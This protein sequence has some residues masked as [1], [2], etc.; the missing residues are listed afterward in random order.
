[1]GLSVPLDVISC[2][3]IEGPQP[4]IVEGKASLGEER[5]GGK[6]SSNC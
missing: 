6:F 5:S 4:Q 3:C 2:D 1:M